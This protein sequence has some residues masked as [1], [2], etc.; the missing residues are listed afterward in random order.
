MAKSY[1]PEVS[2]LLGDLGTIRLG[3]SLCGLA[4]QADDFDEFAATIA[5]LMMSSGVEEYSDEIAGV[6]AAAINF[7]CPDP[8][9]LLD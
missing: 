9:W 7:V 4:G 3:D 2:S 1:G 6:T 5:L 8:R